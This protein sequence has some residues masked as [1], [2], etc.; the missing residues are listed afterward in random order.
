M[1]K[2]EEK[3]LFSIA[4]CDDEEIICNSI[5]KSLKGY[6]DKKL[7]ITEIYSSVENLYKDLSNG[8]YYDL[9]FLDIEFEEMNGIEAGN[10]IRSNLGDEKTQIIYI[11]AYEQYAMDLFAIRPFNFIVK[12]I[13][14]IEIIENVEKAMKLADANSKCYTFHN[15]NSTYRIPYNDIIF[16][17]SRG[18]K[19]ILHTIRTTY[20]V[21]EK[22]DDIEAVAP[23][24]FF[25]IHKSYLINASYVMRWQFDN[26]VLT[27]NIELSIS[28]AYRKTVR[29]KI[30]NKG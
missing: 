2:K 24:N 16:F 15:K 30:L 20:E 5:E 10:R 28:R 1:L 22:L 14:D 29:T 12:P 3:Y 25:R 26:V 4:I 18:R 17:E 23:M 6:I 13:S 27:N 8:V 21:Y 7:V 11:S 19:V 9:I